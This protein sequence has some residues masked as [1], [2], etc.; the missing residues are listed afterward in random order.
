MVPWSEIGFLGC[1]P[2]NAMT[3]VTIDG[4]TNPQE[5]ADWLAGQGRVD[6]AIAILGA[7]LDPGGLAFPLAVDRHARRHDRVEQALAEWQTAIAAGHRAVHSGLAD[8]LE[9]LERFEEALARWDAAIAASE[10]GARRH[11]ARGFNAMSACL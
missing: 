9:G 3:D 6:E 1:T 7:R 11:L 5:R 8:L 4:P 2:H 10:P